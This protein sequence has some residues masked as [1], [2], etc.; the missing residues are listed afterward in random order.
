MLHGISQCGDL[1]VFNGTVHQP[2]PKTFVYSVALTNHKGRTKTSEP[3][4]SKP[5]RVA[6]ESAGKR[7]AS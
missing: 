5:A 7:V 1:C 4:N 2:K 3:I 6:S